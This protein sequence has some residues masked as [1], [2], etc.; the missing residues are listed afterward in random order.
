MSKDMLGPITRAL[1]G[2]ELQHHGLVLDVVNKLGGKN[3]DAVHQSVA[4]A[5]RGQEEPASSAKKPTPIVFF[6]SVLLPATLAKRT[7]K[8]LVGD[9]YG[10]RDLD[11]NGWLPEMQ[12]AAPAGL[13]RVYGFGE[14][15]T[16]AQMLRATLKI[17]DDV[18]T[19]VI[20]RLLIERK[21]LLVLPKLDIMIQKQEKF[22]LQ[23]EGGEDMGLRTD[24][25]SNFIPV[26]DTDGKVCVVGVYRGGGRWRRDVSRLGHGNVWLRER[27][28][29]LSNS[30]ALNL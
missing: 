24:G 3:A 19:D 29:V 10:H 7:D 18:P 9:I 20:E 28:L 5:L 16:F 12:P 8:C 26:L 21:H 30:T 11:I 13:V 17:A 4:T 15:L 22:F 1:V 6:K 27:R 2:V 14:Q 25:Y 23:Q